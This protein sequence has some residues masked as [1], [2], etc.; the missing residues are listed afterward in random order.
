MINEP[1][2]ELAALVATRNLG[3]PM[4]LLPVLEQLDCG[5]LTE[6]LTIRRRDRNL[7]ISQIR[8]V[9]AEFIKLS[10][11]IATTMAVRD[12]RERER[13]VAAGFVENDEKALK[14]CLRKG[15]ECPEQFEFLSRSKAEL[16]RAETD[17]SAVK[18]SLE[19]IQVTSSGISKELLS[20]KADLLA[21]EDE[22]TTIG[23]AMG[24]GNC[25]LPPA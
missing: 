1:H 4:K 22:I 13:D 12:R 5:Q 10:A 19:A 24:A 21:I 25:P 7:F 14:F 9:E 8:T 15:G 17:L 6:E 18:A 11:E 2:K 20:L 16:R 3:D 23:S